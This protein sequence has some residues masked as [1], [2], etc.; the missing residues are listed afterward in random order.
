MLKKWETEYKVDIH[1]DYREPIKLED[2]ATVLVKALIALMII[3]WGI[4]FV[5]FIIEILYAKCKRSL[6]QF[7]ESDIE[8]QIKK[9]EVQPCST[10]DENK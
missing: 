6:K 10:T 4:A 7:Q 5:V 2:D 8:I 9:I 3:G 1:A